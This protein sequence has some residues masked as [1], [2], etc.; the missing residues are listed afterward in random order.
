M[1]KLIVKLKVFFYLCSTHK[2]VTFSMVGR[3]R[4]RDGPRVENRYANARRNN[5]VFCSILSVC[6]HVHVCICVAC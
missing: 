6:M 4:I 3:I 5:L 1:L 2:T